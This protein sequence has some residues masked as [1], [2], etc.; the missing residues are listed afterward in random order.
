MLEYERKDKE[1]KWKSQLL[2]HIQVIGGKGKRTIGPK[3]SNRLY[4]FFSAK[5]EEKQVIIKDI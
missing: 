1:A 3:L 4:V 2:Q 5:E